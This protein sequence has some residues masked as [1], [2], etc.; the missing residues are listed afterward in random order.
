MI[1]KE[2]VKANVLKLL[3]IDSE[4]YED[5]VDILVDGAM[6]KLKNEGVDSINIDSD[7]SASLDYCICVSYQVAMDIDADVDHARL[8]QQYIT[9]VNTLRTSL[10]NV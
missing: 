1:T 6:N 3:P 5:K 7:T 10:I 2:Y 8:M 4:L 9:R